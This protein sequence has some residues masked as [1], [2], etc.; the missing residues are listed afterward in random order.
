PDFAREAYR[1]RPWFD[2]TT[3]RFRAVTGSAAAE[4]LPAR[5]EFLRLMGFLA[6]KWPHTLSIQPGGSGRAVQAS[7]RIRLIA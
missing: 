2:G 4:A 7:E 1:A 6:G 3:E 5:M